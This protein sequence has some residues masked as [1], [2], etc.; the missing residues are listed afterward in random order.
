MDPP[1]TP[2][3]QE[4]EA[5]T[6]W[7]PFFWRG[8]A[9]V[10]VYGAAVGGLASGVG[11]S[12]RDLVGEGLAVQ[13]YYALGLFVLGGLDLGTPVGGPALGRT[14]LWSAYFL[15]PIITASAIVETAIRIIDPVKLRVRRFSDHVVIGGAGRLT[16]LYV[17]KLRSQ[18]RRRPIVVVEQKAE[19][20]LIPELRD[21]HRAVIVRG[22]V[23]SDQVLRRIRAH[24][25]HR[26]L[27]L[28]GDN[29]SN[30]DAAS[31]ILSR[32]TVT[33]RRIVVHVSDLGLIR[34]TEGSSVARS[35]EIFNGHESAAVHLMQ[36]HLLARFHRTPGRDP[37]VLA[38]FGRFGQTVL[39]QLQ[40]DAAGKFGPVI[41]LDHDATRYARAF[42]DGPGFRDDYQRVVI[43]GDLR[44]PDIWSHIHDI[45]RAEGNDPV[46]IAGS[47]NDGTN[48][49]AALAVRSAHPDAYVIVR[50]RRASPFTDEIAVEAGI[51]SFNLGQLIQSG[52]PSDWF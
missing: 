20:P 23:A 33:A 29:F 10:A 51:H 26:V 49:T 34:Q 14:L 1:T 32:S 52:M 44:D 21:V 40:R 27:L 45:L 30:L 28:T 47:G 31:K 5:R 18:D 3:P 35:C 41:V 38:G 6:L 19:H 4:R 2:P 9:F 7:R 43:D 15:A 37:V 13:A 16:L 24:R 42:D 36:E 48:L 46:V 12:E 8:L 22:D 11:V 50:N 25:A 39:D 17:R